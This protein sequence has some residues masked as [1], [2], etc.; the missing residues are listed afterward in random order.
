MTERGHIRGAVALLAVF[1]ATGLWLEA[2]IG[3]RAAGWVDDA[4]RREMLRLG[5]AHGGLL[6]L[7]NLAAAYAMRRLETPERW[8]SR[9][10]LALLA[11]APLVGLGFFG[12]GLWHGPT[13]PG[14]IVLIVPAGAMMALA[15]LVAIALVRD[16]GDHTPGSES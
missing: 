16:G 9:C 12:G 7:V 11:S 2:M 8:A 1:L 10:R 4:L 3:L 13:D 5:H 14:P 6:S 15:A